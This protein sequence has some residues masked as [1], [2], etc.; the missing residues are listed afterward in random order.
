AF[1]DDEFTIT[2]SDAND[3]PTDI[4]LTPSSIPEHSAVGST[5]GT[6]AAVDQDA[7]DTH[8]FAFDS[9][10]GDDDNASFA[11]VGNGLRTAVPLDVP[12]RASYT[13]R[14]VADD[15][16]GGTFARA[17]AITVTDVN[18]SPTDIAL[19]NDS[20]AE[21]Q[22]PGAGVGTFSATDPDPPGQTFTFSLEG[23]G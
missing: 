4:T 7:S 17:L 15:G 10:A 6:L 1:T 18:E 8:T 23:D 2:V 9:G 19:S 3:A 11:I 21:N 22:A 13:V 16:A 12:V 14:A 5:V 20:V